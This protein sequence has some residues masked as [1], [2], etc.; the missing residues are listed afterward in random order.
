M[1][2]N[3]IIIEEFCQDGC[4]ISLKVLTVHITSK[5]NDSFKV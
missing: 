4:D 1:E 2:P 5:K 3:I